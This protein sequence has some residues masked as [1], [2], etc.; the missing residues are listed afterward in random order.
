MRFKPTRI[1][2]KRVIKWILPE[3]QLKEELFEFQLL[4]LPMQI[5]MKNILILSNTINGK[6]ESRILWKA[7][8]KILNFMKNSRGVVFQLKD[9]PHYTSLL[10]IKKTPQILTGQWAEGTADCILGYFETFELVIM[11]KKRIA[12]EENKEVKDSVKLR[13]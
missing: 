7:P 8:I 2:Q 11:N 5:Q 12:T 13:H 4:P 10:H 3:T 6:H 1:F 9:Y